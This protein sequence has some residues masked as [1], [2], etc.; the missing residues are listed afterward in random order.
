M[1][2]P[3]DRGLEQKVLIG[4][5]FTIALVLL[6]AVYFLTEPRR[7]AAAEQ[8]F[9]ERSQRWGAELYLLNCAPCHGEQG[10]G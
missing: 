4:L 3:L 9:L 5:L 8:Q 7:L 2:D 1:N 6:T 10:Q